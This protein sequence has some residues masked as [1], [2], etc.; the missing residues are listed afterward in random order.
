[1]TDNA[2]TATMDQEL[3]ALRL[4]AVDDEVLELAVDE[5]GEERWLYEHCLVGILLSRKQYNFNVFKSRMASVWQPGRGVQIQE[6]T[7]NPEDRL[8]LFRFFHVK[9]IKWVVENGPWTFD[10]HLLVTHELRK[11]EHPADV[12][13]KTTDMWVQVHNLHSGFFSSAVAKALGN[14]VGS[15]IAFDEKSMMMSAEMVMR[16]RVRL[17][18]REPIKKEKK[19]KRP[20]GECVLAKFRY[21]KLPTF[22]FICCRLGHFDRHCEIYFC[23]PDDQIVRLWDISLRAPPRRSN[24]LGSDK[25]LVEE[26][27]GMDMDN[28]LQDKNV[29]YGRATA[30]HSLKLMGNL[31]ATKSTSSMELGMI[32]YS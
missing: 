32:L 9:D 2:P 17:D 27:P 28:T 14:F 23:L 8:L 4:L 10:G 26:E 6:I 19:L 1:M 18:I 15:F 21:E 22:C 7:S 20:G 13:L 5:V 25:W 24:T 12:E 16:V 3:A 11:G 29:N 31:G 30:S